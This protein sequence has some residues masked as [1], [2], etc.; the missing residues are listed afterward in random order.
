MLPAWYRREIGLGDEGPDVRIVRRKLGL[1]P[2]GIYDR[3]VE[4]MIRGMGGKKGRVTKAT[5]GKLGEAEASKAGLVPEWYLRPLQLWFEGEDV[6]ALRSLL[7]LGRADNR[8]D[9]DCEAAVRRVQSAHGMRP[10]GLVDEETA[11]VL[12]ET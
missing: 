8:Y 9:P 2:D 12:G 3:T 1:D 6:R 4:E 10:T 5:A 11:K 7:G